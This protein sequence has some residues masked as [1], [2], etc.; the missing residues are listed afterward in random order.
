MLSLTGSSVL[1]TAG[2]ST[3]GAQASMSVSIDYEV[4][5]AMTLL[6][7]LWTGPMVPPLPPSGC[8]GGLLV[9][10]AISEGLG[11][12]AARAAEAAAHELGERPVKVLL[13]WYPT[14]AGIAMF[15]QTKPAKVT[16]VSDDA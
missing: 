16:I 13:P 6:G 2:Y 4:A 1:S 9:S 8:Y 10:S 7:L 12:A 11:I 14:H 15:D 3:G 5:E